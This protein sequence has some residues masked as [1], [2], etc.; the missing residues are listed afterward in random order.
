MTEILSVPI[1]V[2]SFIDRDRTWFKSVRGLNCTE[3]PQ[4]WSLCFE[5]IKEKDHMV[6]EDTMLDPRF[7]ENPLVLRGPKIRFYASA[8]LISPK[9]TKIGSLAIMDHNPRTISVAQL[10]VMKNF[11]E[12]IIQQLELRKSRLNQERT[13]RSIT[14][15]NLTPENQDYEFKN[16]KI[17]IVDDSE[18]SQNLFV[19]YLKKYGARVEIA[20]NGAVALEMLKTKSFDVV[21]MDIRMP[22]M[23]GITAMKEFRTWEKDFSKKKTPIIAVTASASEQV[24]I[25]STIAGCD[26]FLPKPVN[27]NVILDSIKKLSA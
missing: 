9:G 23:D 19:A 4:D 21:L 27:K 16:L 20:E 1:A 17:L 15:P 3:A 22:I 13:Q 7:K 18:D 10:N 12:M 2:I 6:V 14:L 25:L 24:K 8:L 5:A 11:A 26:L